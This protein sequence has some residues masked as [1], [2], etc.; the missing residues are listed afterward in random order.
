MG[1]G[2]LRSPR[3]LLNLQRQIALRNSGECSV[4]DLQR[5]RRTMDC[6]LLNE[7]LSASLGVF[8]NTGHAPSLS[9]LYFQSRWV[10]M[11]LTFSVF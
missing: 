9:L 7:A 4:L 11:P 1:W 8:T 2:A 5:L 10:A 3:L 6:S